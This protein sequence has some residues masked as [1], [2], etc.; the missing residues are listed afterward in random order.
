MTP[1][2]DRRKQI[3]VNGKFFAIYRTKLWGPGNSGPRIAL[4]IPIECPG[5]TVISG[6]LRIPEFS[7]FSLTI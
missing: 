5:F 7:G 1:P 6:T 2:A 4:S 3:H